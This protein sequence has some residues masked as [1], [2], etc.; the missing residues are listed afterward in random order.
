MGNDT[1]TVGRLRA[2]D[3]I[4]YAAAEL[5]EYLEVMRDEPVDGGVR[6]AP[7]LVVKARGD[8]AAAKRRWQALRSDLFRREETLH[9]ALDS[10]WFV[11][12]MDNTFGVSPAG[13]P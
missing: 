9:R 12:D 5:G 4:P 6:L 10:Y 13:S 8:D 2:T 11:D 7:A 3:P 1:I